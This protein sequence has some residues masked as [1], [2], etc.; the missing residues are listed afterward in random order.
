[1]SKMTNY[2]RFDYLYCSE[3]SVETELENQSGLSKFV[4][5][6]TEVSQF[7]TACDARHLQ[8]FKVLYG[9]TDV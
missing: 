2:C 3:S 8:L 6:V 7:I 9:A 5:N 4:R 1:M